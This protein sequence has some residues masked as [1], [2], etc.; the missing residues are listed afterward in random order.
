MTG[1]RRNPPS[2]N[3]KFDISSAVNRGLKRK[4]VGVEVEPGLSPLTLRI[5]W[6]ERGELS[7]QALPFSV[8]KRMR[9]QH[10]D[11]I[12]ILF[13]GSNNSMVSWDVP[14]TYSCSQESAVCENNC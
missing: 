3:G 11:L 1:R 10:A 13:R 4:R 12:A 8:A 14:R 2:I 6:L 5:Q 7:K 9:P